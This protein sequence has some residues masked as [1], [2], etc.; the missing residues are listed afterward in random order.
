MQGTPLFPPYLGQGSTGP[1]VNVLGL[2]MIALEYGRQSDIVLDGIY[3]PRGKIA[4]AVKR[5][6]KVVDIRQ[7][8]DFGPETRA[9]MEDFHGIDVDFLTVEMFQGKTIASPK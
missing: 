1:A 2:L 4:E 5:F 9:E 7:D 8:G 6:Q 3:T